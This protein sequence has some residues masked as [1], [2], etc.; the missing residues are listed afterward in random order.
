MTPTRG[1]YEEHAAGRQ[2]HSSNDHPEPT[3]RN[4]DEPQPGV[5]LVHLGERSRRDPYS[6]DHEKQE[7]HLGDFHA[8]AMREGDEPHVATMLLA[9]GRARCA[10]R[11]SLR[12]RVQMIPEHGWALAQ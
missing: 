2:E 8:G 7:S 5:C 9:K 4:D 1:D 10:Q 6:R 3:R 11:V 12:Q